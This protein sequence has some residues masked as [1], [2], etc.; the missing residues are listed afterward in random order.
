MSDQG[1]N[2]LALCLKHEWKTLFVRKVEL[3]NAKQTMVI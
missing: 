2:T 1:G 3:S